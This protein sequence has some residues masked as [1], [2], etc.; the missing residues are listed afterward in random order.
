M[1]KQRLPFP[2]AD[3]HVTLIPKYTAV[4]FERVGGAK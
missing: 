1:N 3:G 4:L 2:A